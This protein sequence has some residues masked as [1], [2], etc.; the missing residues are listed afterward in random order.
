MLR[1]EPVSR[2]CAGRGKAACPI[3]DA[4]ANM[5]ARVVHDYPLRLRPKRP[6]QRASAI[7]REGSLHIDES[8][9]VGKAI[10]KHRIS[11]ARHIHIADDVATTRNGP[12][13]EFFG[14]WVKANDGVGLGAGLV[15]PHGIPREDDSVWLRLG[16]TRRRPFRNLAGCRIE[17]PQKPAREVRVPDHVIRTNCDTPRSRAGIGQR[18]F[19][20][21]HRLSVDTRNFVGAEVDEEHNV[22]RVE[23]HTIG[24]RLRRW[25]SHELHVTRRWI[26][27]A[28]HVGLLHGKPQN[29]VAIENESMRVLRLWS[30]HWI[31][32]D[33][34]APGI[35]L[36]DQRRAIAGKPDVAVF[37]F[38]EAV[39]PGT[40]GLEV[41]L[42]HRTGL[43]IEPSELIG[44]LSRP[45]KRSVLGGKRIMWSRTRCRYRP[46]LDDRLDRSW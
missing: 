5:R 21:L 25:R 46:F 39:R 6:R 31:F 10:G 15:V 11:L 9:L 36:A 33:G 3:A 42:L 20:D 16:P 14:S 30:G 43:R 44:Q 22:F 26:E 45:P 41:I 27:P 7:H 19:G 32:G 40:R 28:Y 8:H 24:P 23:R 35:E 4:M 37:V 38:G 2:Q 13:L 34:T 18:I 17:S 12:A 1:H 29:A